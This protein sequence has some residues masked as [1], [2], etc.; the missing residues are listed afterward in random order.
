MCGCSRGF[1]GWNWLRI[2]THV[3]SN[4]ATR[5]QQR[6]PG[7]RGAWVSVNS[8]GSRLLAFWGFGLH[9]TRF[10]VGKSRF[11]G[12][13]FCV[14]WKAILKN[15]EADYSQLGYWPS[16][17]QVLGRSFDSRHVGRPGLLGVRGAGNGRSGCRPS[18]NQV[19]DRKS[20]FW[21]RFYIIGK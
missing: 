5:Q 12:T 15:R 21:G 9:E 16:R 2:S 13:G 3:P 6:L 10:W 20:R 11:G 18:R 4:S 7:W 1:C 17:N 14:G 8:R 19:S